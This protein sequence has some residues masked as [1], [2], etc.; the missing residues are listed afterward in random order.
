[1]KQAALMRRLTSI[2]L[3]TKLVGSW[4]WKDG[5][6]LGGLSCICLDYIVYFILETSS[7]NLFFAG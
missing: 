4:E 3:Q 2:K 6:R 1:M 5:C 7:I